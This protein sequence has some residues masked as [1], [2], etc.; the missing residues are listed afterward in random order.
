LSGGQFGRITLYAKSTSM[1]TTTAG[2][3]DRAPGLSSVTVLGGTAA[4]SD[5]VAGR[6]QQAVLQ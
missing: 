1:P 5:L 6:A 4:V 3:L 2:W